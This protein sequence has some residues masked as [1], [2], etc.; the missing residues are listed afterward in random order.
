MRRGRHLISS[1]KAA[2][3]AGARPKKARKSQAE[4]V[5]KA[6]YGSYS[7]LDRDPVGAPSP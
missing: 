3:K 4:G 6:A 5:A 2:R 7:D 1:E